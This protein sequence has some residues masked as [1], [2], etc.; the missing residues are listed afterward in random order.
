M[1]T[2]T[3]ENISEFVISG[4]WTISASVKP[5]LGSDESKQV[6]LRYKLENVPVADVIASSLK[7]KR[8]N[9]QSKARKIFNSITNG[10]MIVV[11]YIGGRAPVDPKANYGLWF[12][13]LS[14]EEQQ[15]EIERLKTL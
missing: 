13:S 12:A 10:A 3:N 6:T 4:E 11:N 9:W 2:I 14:K 5:E 8:I 15:A 7:D 1:V